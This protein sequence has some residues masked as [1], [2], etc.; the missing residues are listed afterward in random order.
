MNDPGS[1]T[2]TVDLGIVLARR[3]AGLTGAPPRVIMTLAGRVTLRELVLRLGLPGEYVGFITV[4]GNKRDWDT[5]V[6]PGDE[7]VLIPYVTGG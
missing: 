7:I 5:V 4:N 1:Y 3:A 6:E 2:V